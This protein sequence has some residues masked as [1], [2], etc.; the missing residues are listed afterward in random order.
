MARAKTVWGIDIGQCALK[1]VKLADL[2]EVLEVVDFE[3]IEHPEILSQSEADKP[4]LIRQSLEQFLSSHNIS[5]STIALA[6]PG[7]SSFTR[8][9]KPPPVDMKELP[10][11]IQYE[12]AQQIP[13]PIDEVV[14]RW[15]PFMSEDSPDMEVGIFAMKRQDI[16]EVLS[17]LED[18]GLSAD[19]VQVA[20]LALY[21]FMTYDEQQASEGATLLADVGA[22]KTDLV[23]ADG[24]H[25]WTRTI[26]IGGNSF[27]EALTR[28]FKLSFGKAE[29]LK[30]TAA[31]SKYARQVFQAMRPVF[32]DLVQEIQRSVGY[33]ISLHREA[34]FTRLLGLGNGF[35]LPG[36]QKFLE[37][38]LNIAVV[39]LDRLKHVTCSEGLNVPEFEENALS[40]GVAY[41][42]AV[43]A[44]RPTRVQTNLV[45]AEV[46]RRRVWAKKVPWFVG[47]A[48]ALLAALACPALR[49][50]QDNKAMPNMAANHTVLRDVRNT[51]ESL[52]RLQKEYEGLQGMGQTEEGQIAKHMAMFDYRDFWPTMQALIAGSIRHVTAAEDQ[53]VD[54][55]AQLGAYV[56]AT[57]DGARR[58]IRDQIAA[59]PRPAR[60]VLVIQSLQSQYADDLRSLSAGHGEG[61]EP[62]AAGQRGFLVT[63]S[64]RT[65]LP[66]EETIRRLVELRQHSIKAAAEMPALSVVSCRTVAAEATGPY[67][68]PM[69]PDD[70]TSTDTQFTVTWLV[71]VGAE[72]KSV[73]STI[74]IGGG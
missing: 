56:T 70:D 13:F 19:M 31:T 68:D 58:A 64:G 51:V 74:S 54:V 33:Y 43:Q 34:K 20:P 49:A 11:I 15:Q 71:A 25:I 44:L 8:F 26:Q 38:N 6:V 9:V 30:R 36:L 62:I 17:Y 65:P 52:Q 16:A 10:R 21:N 53:T 67:V 61:G 28:A 57:A 73:P 18:V 63:V 37:Q 4:L 35:R 66:K 27:T 55:Q 24:P 72:T 14:W 60:A 40:F 2:G 42:L 5:G 3:V 59:T 22:E 46:E 39:R 12:A 69:F 1:A 32:A 45:P 23:V 29:K 50:W 7:Q 48:V 41:G 47:A